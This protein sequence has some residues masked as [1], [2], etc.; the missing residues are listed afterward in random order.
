MNKTAFQFFCNELTDLII[1]TGGPSARRNWCAQGNC[2]RFWIPAINRECQF[3]PCRGGGKIAKVV[4]T[5]EANL[6]L[7]NSVTFC[8]SGL[9][10][11]KK[12]TKIHFRQWTESWIECKTGHQKW[13]LSMLG[14]T[15]S[16]RWTMWSVVK[17]FY[18]SL[19]GV[20]NLQPKHQFYRRFSDLSLQKLNT[21][22]R[23]NWH[24]FTLWFRENW[25]IR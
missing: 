24:H 1:E 7:K 19:R 3:L 18:T 10:E 15:L 12:T 14:D 5:G 25:L 11:K 22:V 23:I 20:V 2:Y 4:R 17:R 13:E 16:C 8:I 21:L 9:F 6:Y